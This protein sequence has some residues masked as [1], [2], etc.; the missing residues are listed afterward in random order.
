MCLHVIH[1][2]YI[3]FLSFSFLLHTMWCSIYIYNIICIY[4][5]IH[6]RVY[7]CTLLQFIHVFLFLLFFLSPSAFLLS[8]LSTSFPL[9]INQSS[10]S[11][12]LF[13]SLSFHFLLSLLTCLSSLFSSLPFS[14]HIL[15]Y[16]E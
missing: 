1:V 3:A 11:L 15:S 16:L 4:V 12:S 5:I 6:V 7:T 2:M 8:F 14:W 9:T 10:F 13:L